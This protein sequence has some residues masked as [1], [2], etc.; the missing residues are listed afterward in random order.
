MT[1]AII[2]RLNFGQITAL[3]LKGTPLLDVVDQRVSNSILPGSGL[4][5]AVVMG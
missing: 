4:A 2:R 5:I 1:H 3:N